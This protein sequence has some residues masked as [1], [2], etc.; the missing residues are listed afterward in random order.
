VKIPRNDRPRYAP[1][2]EVSPIDDHHSFAASSRRA[3]DKPEAPT[4]LSNKPD[5]LP[6]RTSHDHYTGLK[7]SSRKQMSL[8][9]QEQI[10]GP[11]EG[12]EGS[13]SELPSNERKRKSHGGSGRG[14]L[15]RRQN[16]VSDTA[17]P[18]KADKNAQGRD[19]QQSVLQQSRHHESL[20]QPHLRYNWD[21]PPA[22]QRMEQPLQGER[23][24]RD[25]ASNQ[26]ISLE[27]AGAEIL[28]GE[29]EPADD[30]YGPTEPLFEPPPERPKD[31]GRAAKNLGL[32]SPQGIDGNWN[33]ADSVGE[34]NYGHAGLWVQ[35]DGN[36]GI[37]NVSMSWSMT[38]R[39][40]LMVSQRMV[41]KETWLK[42]NKRIRRKF[43]HDMSARIPREV[44]MH[45]SMAG[46]AR[47]W[48]I[49][50]YLSWGLYAERRIF[51]IYTHYYP[52]GDLSKLIKEHEKVEGALDTQ[53][54]ELDAP[55]SA[56]VLWCIFEAL[57]TAAYL[58]QHG[59]LPDEPAPED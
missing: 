47:A 20:H 10:D 51:R 13:L 48:P 34:G 6:G 9:A 38:S 33:F 25:V 30:G 8:V 15:S 24:E 41:V 17:E 42:T 55:V 19:R 31:L 40:Q 32:G 58:M 5:H 46:L 44:H 35:Y 37:V 7:P 12:L 2:A 22:G 39:M 14:T 16:S 56:R 49:A 54:K 28:E 27:D 53:G 57:A 50:A 18:G 23:P 26:H 52:H 21:A 43:W 11:A 29:P 1:I 4:G 59:T 36:A 45:Q 3:K